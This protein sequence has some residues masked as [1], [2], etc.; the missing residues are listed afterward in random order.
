M[1]SAQSKKNDVDQDRP[2]LHLFL[3]IDPFGKQVLVAR[4]YRQ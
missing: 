3:L 2:E 1:D 4:C